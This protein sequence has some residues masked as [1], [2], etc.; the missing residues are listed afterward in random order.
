MKVGLFVFYPGT[1]WF[2]GGGESYLRTVYAALKTLGSDV[3]LLDLWNPQRYDVVH[4][5][6]SSY[7][8]ADFVLAA[9]ATGAKVVVTPCTYSV[10][11]AWQWWCWDKVDR[12]LPVETVYGC[13]RRLFHAADVILPGSAAE[14]AQLS[15]YFGLPRGRFTTVPYT[16]EERF[17]SASPALFQ[18]TFG[19]SD[20][21]LMV[22]RI[23]EIKGQIRLLQALDGIDIPIVFIGGRDPN[24]PTYFERFLSECR[25]RPLVHY[26]G[27]LSHE[28]EL[29]ASAFAAAKVHA[30]VSLNEYPGLANFEAALAGANIVTLR[31]PIAE[32]YLG[33]DATY[34]HP[35]SLASIREAVLTAYRAPRDSRLRERLL[36][37]IVPEAVAMKLTLIYQQL[38]SEPSNR[39]AGASVLMAASEKAA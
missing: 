6:G 11:P 25:R 3:E 33:D 23:N 21:V 19:L 24:D 4:V 12:L 38:V 27:V 16:C 2:P 14:V 7:H 18:K 39:E 20:T 8:V 10:R 29:L 22:G 13:R 36:A 37:T 31:N 1:I 32:E 35:R 17:A 15:R 9:K 30:L 34:C 5:F 28:D 26:L